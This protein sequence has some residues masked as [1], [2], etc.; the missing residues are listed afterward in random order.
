MKSGRMLWRLYPSYLLITLVALVLVT[1]Y[2]SASFRR[3]Y[4]D[5]AAADL[6]IRAQLIL[7]MIGPGFHP[8]RKAVI[9][10]L[11]KRLG[12]RS[13]TRFTVVA[14]NG[15]VIG[16]TWEDPRN[17]ELHNTRPELSAALE[18]QVGQSV[19]FSNTLQQN[20]MYVAVP[21]K[22]SGI[23]VGA[24][25]SSVAVTSLEEELS[26]VSRRIALGGL[27]IAALAALISLMVSRSITRPLEELRHGAARIARGDF[28]STLPTA[29]SEEI[30]GLARAMNRMAVDLDRR[31]STEI[32][33]RNEQE[34]ILASMVEG[35]VAFDS[36]ERIINL[37]QTAARLFGIDS[38]SASGKA[39]HELVRNVDLHR[40]V[41]Q[42]LNSS[43]P[44]EG[45]IELTTGG[46]QQLQIHGTTLLDSRGAAIGGVIVLNDITKLR[47]LET[48]RREFVANVSH[49]LRTPITSIKGFLE[50]LRDGAIDHPEDARRFLGIMT[51]HVDRLNL[52]IEDLLS[53]SRIE[54]GVEDGGIQLTELSMGQVI[55]A[56]IQ[57]CES[58]ASAAGIRLVT[59]V[60][61]D[62]TARL[63]PTLFE[64][65]IINLITNAIAHSESGHLVTVGAAMRPNGAVVYVV[66]E[67][68]GITE[69]E[70]SRIFERFYRVDKA[71]SRESGGTGLGLA[72]VKHIVLAHRGTIEV[73]SAPGQGSTFT[74]CLPVNGNS[75]P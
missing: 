42:V 14:L 2:A 26:I 23:T 72:I 51:G 27:L 55:M 47:N 7:P 12:H 67:G 9:D 70:Q 18:G 28:D 73:E 48:I 59:D 13:G 74:I 11:C 57:S 44:V 5:Q 53:L 52:I 65:A 41:S 3:Y 21:I 64:R 71:R 49:E 58:L 46:E 1:W 30:G 66:D 24:L 10:S 62:F 40:L 56:A 68:C 45:H 34:A 39:V 6:E 4:L 19:R 16:D 22:R 31:I 54:Q 61:I 36:S 60:E 20:L 33:R 29:G 43:E 63:N 25:R 75:T 17:M 69:I 38:Q 15:T 37:N 50:T 32:R 35:V 8:D